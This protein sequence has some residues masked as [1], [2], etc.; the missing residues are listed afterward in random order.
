MTESL[1]TPITLIGEILDRLLRIE[2]SLHTI[3]RDKTAKE[4]YST[5]EIA[6]QLGKSEYT[7]R[8]WCR[9]GRVKAIMKSYTRGAH[10]EWLIS[11]EE[12]M[13]IKNHGLL[14]SR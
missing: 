9:L 12:F 6:E 8:E 14:P 7:V 4:W 13:R 11:H 1:T 2:V 5:A 3:I 10:P